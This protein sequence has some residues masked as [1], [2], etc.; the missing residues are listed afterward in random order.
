MDGMIDDGELGRWV[1]IPW[2]I[3]LDVT[4]EGVG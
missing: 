2:G 4:T 3:D 1:L